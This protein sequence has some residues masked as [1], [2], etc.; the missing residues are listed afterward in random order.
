M[1]KETEFYEL[2]GVQP[3]AEPGAIKKVWERGHS[4]MHNTV[5][6]PLSDYARFPASIVTCRVSSLI[7]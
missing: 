3:D 2:L 6:S 5:Y 1:V 4:K 7:G